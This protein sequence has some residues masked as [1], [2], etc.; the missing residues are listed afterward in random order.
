MPAIGL[1]FLS[2]IIAI[3][4]LSAARFYAAPS[5]EFATVTVEPGDTLWTI[6]D[7]Q[8]PAGSAVQ[9]TLDAI[10]AANHLAGAA[11]FPGQRIKIPR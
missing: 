11:V 7:R 2:A 10:R 4:A 8:T 1:A 6:A 5:Q 9:E 3:P